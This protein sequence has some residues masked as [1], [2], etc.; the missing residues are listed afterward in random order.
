[1]PTIFKRLTVTVGQGASDEDTNGKRIGVSD[2]S[3][4]RVKRIKTTFKK[5]DKH[6]LGITLA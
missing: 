2:N 5:R 1:M 3:A 6:Q 4:Q